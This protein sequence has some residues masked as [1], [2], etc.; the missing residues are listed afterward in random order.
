MRAL[1]LICTG[2][3][4]QQDGTS[5]NAPSTATDNT[6]QSRLTT[7]QPDAQNQEGVSSNRDTPAGSPSAS[8]SASTHTNSVTPTPTPRPAAIPAMTWE[9]SS[10]LRL[11]LIQQAEVWQSLLAGHQSLRDFTTSLVTQRICNDFSQELD[12]AI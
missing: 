6:A 11:A 2:D 9:T 3:T 5:S 12:Q 8:A 10:Q 1:H 4:Q 7:P